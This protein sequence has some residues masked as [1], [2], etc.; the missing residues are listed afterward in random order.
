MVILFLHFYL[1]CFVLG[2]STSKATGVQTDETSAIAQAIHNDDQHISDNLSKKLLA[3]WGSP[4]EQELGKNVISN[5]LMACQT[6]FHS[7]SGCIGMNIS[8][9]LRMDTAG[10]EGSCIAASQNMHISRNPEVAKVSHLYSVLTKVLLYYTISYIFL[11]RKYL[12]P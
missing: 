11:D 8:S 6:D 7:L 9:K 12:E 1:F 4:N 5:L 3:I 10:D 2:V